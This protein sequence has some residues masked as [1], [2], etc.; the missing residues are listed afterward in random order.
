MNG[1]IEWAV[2]FALIAIFG[3]AA[4]AQIKAIYH[5]V[6]YWGGM[7]VQQRV[8]LSLL[9]MFALLWDKGIPNEALRHRSLFLKWEG[10]FVAT[11]VPLVILDL[12]I[13]QPNPAL[14]TD[15]AHPRTPVSATR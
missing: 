10:I 14:N 5:F 2:L 13:R 6:R 11:I 7:S 12:L 4:F 8:G 9:G 1:A 15:V 3:F